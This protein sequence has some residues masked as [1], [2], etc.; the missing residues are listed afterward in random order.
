MLGWRAPN[1]FPLDAINPLGG[2][3]KGREIMIHVQKGEKKKSQSVVHMQLQR[4]NA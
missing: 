2:F 4:R 1:G 3:N